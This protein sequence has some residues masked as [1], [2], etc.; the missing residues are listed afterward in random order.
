M[1]TAAKKADMPSPLKWFA[2]SERV[3]VCPGQH[4]CKPS[5]YALAMPGDRFLTIGEFSRRVGVSV[6]VLRA[7]ERRYGVPHP[8]RAAGGRRLYTR[9]DERVIAAMRRAVASGIPPATAAR[10]A[11]VATA[12]AEP[13]GANGELA[14]LAARLR[15]ALD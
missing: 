2:C 12:G 4:R 3:K 15:D 13:A 7:W 9:E 11:T 6:D 1:S 8:A 5:Q 14:R 10:D